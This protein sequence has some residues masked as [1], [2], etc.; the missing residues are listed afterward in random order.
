[1]WG[2]LNIHKPSDVTSRDVVNHVQ[3]VVRPHKAGHAGT[4]DPLATGVLVV[5]V[6]AATR[7]IEFVQALSEDVCGDIPV[8]P[9]ERHG[10]HRGTG[11]GTGQ[12]ADPD[13]RRLGRGIA[14]ILRRNSPAST[15]LFRLESAGASRLRAG[16]SWADP[17]SSSHGPL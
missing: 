10:G 5:C 11:R 4:L 6:G 14:A 9:R 16:A 12:S 15:R 7:L 1:M 8:G 13:A 17:W 3:R 2:L